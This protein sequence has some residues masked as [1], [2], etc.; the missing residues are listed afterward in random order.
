VLKA[1]K[2][3]VVTLLVRGSILLYSDDM[4]CLVV[5]FQLQIKD[6]LVLCLELEWESR[7]AVCKIA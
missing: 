2:P 1:A 6:V 3:V 7:N 4:I 5:L